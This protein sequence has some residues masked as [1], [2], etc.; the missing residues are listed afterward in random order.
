MNGPTLDFSFLDATAR[1][2]IAG[3]CVAVVQ[4]VKC[5]GRG[6]RGGDVAAATKFRAHSIARAR[7]SVF[8]VFYKLDSA[9]LVRGEMLHHVG[10]F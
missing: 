1:G 4:A 6:E 2:W 8:V 3:A 9:L 7:L 5:G 10:F